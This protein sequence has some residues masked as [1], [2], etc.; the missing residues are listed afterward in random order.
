MFEQPLGREKGHKK[1]EN[2]KIMEK[3]G[4]NE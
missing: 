2:G 3:K 1:K 4:W